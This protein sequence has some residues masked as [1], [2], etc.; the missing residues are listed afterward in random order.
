[1]GPAKE[2]WINV[3]GL[4]LPFEKGGHRYTET[5]VEARA[6]DFPLILR[7]DCIMAARPP[8]IAFGPVHEQSSTFGTRER[9]TIHESEKA[10]EMIPSI[11]HF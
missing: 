2:Q 1:M 7:C 9:S 5:V 6:S 10:R 3:R 4:Q 8:L 11:S